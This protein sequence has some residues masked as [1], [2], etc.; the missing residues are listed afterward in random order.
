MNMLEGD[1][2]TPEYRRINPNGR[3]PAIAD[4]EPIGGGAPLPVFESGAILLYLAET[5]GRLLPEN[6]RRRSQAQQWPM[7]TKASFGP[8]P[9]QAHHFIRTQL[10]GQA[11]PLHRPR[12]D[13]LPR[14]PRPNQ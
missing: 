2:L 11:D 8:Q 14:P 13:N 7:W 6:P 9:G 5:S 12:N 10:A 4:H 3:L 1:H